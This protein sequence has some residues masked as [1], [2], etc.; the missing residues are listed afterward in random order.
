MCGDGAVVR[1][2]RV[3]GGGRAGGRAGGRH[4]A[5]AEMLLCQMLLCQ[6]LLCQRL[7]CLGAVTLEG[8]VSG[9]RVYSFR[10]FLLELALAGDGGG[11]RCWSRGLLVCVVLFI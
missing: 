7:L 8:P 5:D 4:R 2:D 10:R 1:S 11:L 6:M 9:W 3:A